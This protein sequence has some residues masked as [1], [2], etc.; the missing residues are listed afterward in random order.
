MSSYEV[1][2]LISKLENG[3]SDMESRQTEDDRDYRFEYETNAYNALAD[4][5]IYLLKKSDSN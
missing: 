5:L 3:K 4:A 2:D 1:R